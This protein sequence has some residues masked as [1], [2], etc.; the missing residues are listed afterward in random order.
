[1][2]RVLPPGITP[3]ACAK[4][5]ADFE[6]GAAQR[7]VSASARGD[8]TPVVVAMRRIMRRGWRAVKKPHPVGVDNGPTQA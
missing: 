7:R 2:V 1:V 5:A 8:F 6:P 4:S 3:W